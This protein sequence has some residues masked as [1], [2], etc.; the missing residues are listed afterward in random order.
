MRVGAKLAAWDAADLPALLTLEPT[1]EHRWRTR[2]GDANMNGRAYGGQ[3]L[4]QAMMAVSMGM[5]PERPATMLQ[6]LFLQG[7]MPDE[8]IEF[9]VSTLQDGKRFT[10]RR[11]QGFQANGRQVLDAHASFAMPL[12]APEHQAPSPALDED[13]ESL[14]SLA[15]VPPAWEVRLRGLGGYSLEEKPSMLFRV[16][17]LAQQMSP[18]HAGTRFRFWLRTRHRLPA[19]PGMPAAAFAYLSDWW[20]NFASLG[21]HMRDLDETRR[22]YISSLN[23][24]IWF[25]RAFSPDA[26]MHVECD[27]PVSAQ[28]RGLSIARIH[29]QAGQLVAS[30][31]QECLM[32]YA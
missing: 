10:S 14:P 3:A 32:A 13:P 18:D 25:H 30:T 5:P 2:F 24:N 21:S 22:L 26:W 31:T 8:A 9:E 17:D 28:G 7:S 20:L 16:P 29:N 12:D 6:F 27:S 23:H 1:G 11:V 4:G 15:D 19:S